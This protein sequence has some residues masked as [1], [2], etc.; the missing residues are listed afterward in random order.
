MDDNSCFG[1]GDILTKIKD[2]I[3]TCVMVTDRYQD[4]IP[5]SYLVEKIRSKNAQFT[6]TLIGSEI[7]KCIVQK[8]G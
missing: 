8:F 6:K 2:I 5:R 1:V 7:G 4:K 3:L